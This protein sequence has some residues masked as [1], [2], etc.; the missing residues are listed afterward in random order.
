ML[1]ILGVFTVVVV[2]VSIWAIAKLVKLQK[3][4]ELDIQNNPK[5][6]YTLDDVVKA[7]QYGFKY[8]GESQNDGKEVPVGNVLQW[9]MHRKSL[10]EVP[11]EFSDYKNEGNS[12]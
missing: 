10:I 1:F 7:A 9:L 11:K 2:I 4:V 5:L 12:N 3:K 8:R 6:E